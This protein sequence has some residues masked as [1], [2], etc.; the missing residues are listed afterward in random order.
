LRPGGS[1]GGHNG[2]KHIQQTL[3]TDRYARLRFGIGDDYP[4]GHQID[5]VLSGWSAEQLKTLP[6]HIQL[7]C[8]II[9]Q[10]C[11]SGIEQTMNDYNRR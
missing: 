4:K 1:D 2:L 7:A 3:N 8:E 10:F 5:Y 11:L 9:Q 6:D